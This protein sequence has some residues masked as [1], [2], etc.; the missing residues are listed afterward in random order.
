MGVAIPSPND[1]YCRPDIAYDLRSKQFIK[2]DVSPTLIIRRIG[3]RY[4]KEI[5][6]S[7]I[8]IACVIVSSIIKEPLKQQ[9]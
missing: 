3:G 7:I 8:D 2:L 1:K 6:P 9:R 4:T 5:V